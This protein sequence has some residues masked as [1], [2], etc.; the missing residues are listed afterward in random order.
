MC[1]SGKNQD[2]LGSRTVEL[3]GE[4]VEEGEPEG[5]EAVTASR[6]WGGAAAALKNL[7][8][9]A[10]RFYCQS[11]KLVFAPVKVFKR[12]DFKVIDTELKVF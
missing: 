4:V 7:E 12:V 1:Q 2:Q 5:E 6:R 8:R 9:P 10:E 3:E 11:G